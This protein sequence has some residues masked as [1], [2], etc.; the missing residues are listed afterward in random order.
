[1]SLPLLDVQENRARARRARGLL[2]LA[3]CS[4]HGGGAALTT[5]THVDRG[6]LDVKPM[7]FCIPG[8]EET[9]LVEQQNC[10][11]SFPLSLLSDIC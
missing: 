7:G 3:S 10:S 1:M 5:E 4:G 11:L 6:R 8:P 9:E 2:L